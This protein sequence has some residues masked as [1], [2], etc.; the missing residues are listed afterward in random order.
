M[1]KVVK[2][3]VQDCDVNDSQTTVDM[4]SQ[5]YESQI[6]ELNF[7]INDDTKNRMLLFKPQGQPQWVK[8]EAITW[9][10][11]GCDGFLSLFSRSHDLPPTF[12][13]CSNKECTVVYLF[14]KKFGT[15]VCCKKEC[16]KVKYFI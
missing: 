3:V 14:A 7:D 6:S 5:N 13:R 16:K 11:V 10:C 9:D 8:L 12:V 1:V 2:T 15:C 4:N